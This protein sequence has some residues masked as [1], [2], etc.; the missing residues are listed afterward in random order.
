MPRDPWRNAAGVEIAPMR[1]VDFFNKRRL[2]SSISD[3]PPM[4]A[5]ANYYAKLHATLVAA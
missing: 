1:W 4:E 3:I 2:L 5:E